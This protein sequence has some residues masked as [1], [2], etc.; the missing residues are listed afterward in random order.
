MGAYRRSMFH[1][2]G[3]ARRE[4]QLRQRRQ[5]EGGRLGCK[6]FSAPADRQDPTAGRGVWPIKMPQSQETTQT[7]IWQT[8]RLD[9]A[10]F[11][12]QSRTHVF[13]VWLSFPALRNSST[14]HSEATMSCNFLDESLFLHPV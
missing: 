10:P 11:E 8:V 2:S 5:L 6:R 7:M 14:P 13:P 12:Q 4:R 9:T 3:C 1:N